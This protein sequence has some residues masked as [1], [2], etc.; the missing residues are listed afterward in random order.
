MNNLDLAIQWYE[1]NI[2][3]AK[4]TLFNP[5]NYITDLTTK[6]KGMQRAKE[7]IS[8]LEEAIEILKKENERRKR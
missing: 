2:K 7:L 4:E 6:T 3:I 8:Q 5:D 1:D